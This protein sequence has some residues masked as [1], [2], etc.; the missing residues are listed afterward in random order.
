MSE[1][2]GASIERTLVLMKPDAVTRGILGR[3][4]MR[5][6]NAL[7]KVVGAKMVWIDADLM[8]QHYFDLEEQAGT[9]VYNVTA[10]YMQQSPVIALVLEGVD[11]IGRVRKMLGPSIFPGD[12]PPGTIRGDFG[13]Q[14]RAY[15][16]TR[17]KTMANLVHASGS[18]GDAKREI[19][20]WFKPEELF[21]YEILAE[22]YAF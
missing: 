17:G 1:T 8:R 7:F 13:H 19:E 15:A 4:I 21:S 11:A 12:C 20:L 14:I 18:A 2:A 10:S 9:E 22:K 3:I 6:E 16:N 5:F